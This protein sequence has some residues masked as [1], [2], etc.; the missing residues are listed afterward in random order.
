MSRLHSSGFQ[1]VIKA[2]GIFFF[3][4]AALFIPKV[5]PFL[6]LLSLFFV[7]RTLYYAWRLTEREFVVIN[8]DNVPNVIFDPK[9]SIVR[10]YEDENEE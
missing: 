9:K 2:I 1:N 10:G 7:V 8:R 3:G 5:G 4:L 6:F